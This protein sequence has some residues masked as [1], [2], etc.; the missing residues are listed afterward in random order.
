MFPHSDVKRANS[1]IAKLARIATVRV[2][3]CGVVVR[4]LSG[5]VYYYIG[6]YSRSRPELVAILGGKLIS[7]TVS[8]YILCKS[9]LM[10]AKVA[11]S[12]VPISRGTRQAPVPP[13]EI[14]ILAEDLYVSVSEPE[15][16]D[17]KAPLCKWSF[18]PIDL[19]A[20]PRPGVA[21]G[22]V[23]VAAVQTAIKI[24]SQVLVAVADAWAQLTTKEIAHQL[25]TSWAV[26]AV[27]KDIVRRRVADVPATQAREKLKEFGMAPLPEDV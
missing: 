15:S 22:Q 10:A 17:Q 23:P 5:A 13:E 9:V 27:A 12:A 3:S 8:R 11:V 19:P 24:P 20:D 18:K 7:G 6:Q 21:A 1:Y 4:A 14:D 26:P 16:D 25:S 2:K